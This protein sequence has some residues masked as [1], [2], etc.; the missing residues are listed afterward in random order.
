MKEQPAWDSTTA[1]ALLSRANELRQQ[2]D[3]LSA[4]A[5]YLEIQQ[6]FG[7]TATL[8]AM[9]AHCYFWAT[10]AHQQG[11]S[12]YKEAI[13]WLK[14][15]IAL[16]PDTAEF[17]AELGQYYWM[18]NLDYEQA[19]WAYRKALEFNPNYLPVL[20]SAAILY[21]PPESVFALDEAI[22]WLE[23][24]SRLEPYDSTT[25]YWLGDFYYKAG[26]QHDARREW[27]MALLCPEPLVADLAQIVEKALNTRDA[28]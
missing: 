28:L 17:Y 13:L 16:E 26:R 1:I 11:E 22:N 5:I 18:G 4:L 20:K 14:K 12:G 15:A 24:A 9:I 10:M 19:A 3:Y 7:E 25:H 21:G 2:K 6:K 23:R 27:L 8:L